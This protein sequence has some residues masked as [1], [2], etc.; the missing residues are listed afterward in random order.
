MASTMPASL[1]YDNAVWSWRF[2]ITILKTLIVLI[3]G[4]VLV[5]CT[6]EPPAVRL[7]AITGSDQEPT[8]FFEGFKMVSSKGDA[9]QWIFHARAAQIYE[10]I[11]LAKAQDIEMIYL[12]GGQQQ[13]RLTAK[14]GQLNTKTQ[15]MIAEQDVVIV[16]S[17]GVILN[18]EK[19]NWDQDQQSIYTDQPVRVERR[20]SILNGVGLK[21]DSDLKHIEVLADVQ[22]ELKSL[23]GLNNSD[24]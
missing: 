20:D 1:L 6:P 8:I 7:A 11:N 12:K 13:S 21:A 14:K 5:A 23:K 24:D 10:R 19:L 3:I 4:L 17:D 15:H 2:R 22:I 16:S 9:P 18:T